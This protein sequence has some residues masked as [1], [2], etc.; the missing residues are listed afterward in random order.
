MSE[1][2][3]GQKKRRKEVLEARKEGRVRRKEGRKTNVTCG[4]SGRN[5]TKHRS[6]QMKNS[7]IN[8]KNRNEGKRRGEEWKGL[9]AQVH[10][11]ESA[12]FPI[13][14]SPPSTPSLKNGFAKEAQHSLYLR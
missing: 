9:R 7:R 12:F 2:N 14:P 3:K 11:V 4:W 5:G 1:V 6:T 8:G 10:S 13:P